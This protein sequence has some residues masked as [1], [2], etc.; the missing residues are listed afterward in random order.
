MLRTYSIYKKLEYH[1]DDKIE[2]LQNET[3]WNVLKAIIP[4][5]AVLF[6]KV[7]PND[8]STIIVIS[9]VFFIISFKSIRTKIYKIGVFL[10]IIDFITNFRGINTDKNESEIVQE[11]DN[12]NEEHNNNIKE[13]YFLYSLYPSKKDFKQ[14]Y[15]ITIENEL[16]NY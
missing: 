16:F 13:L 12:F 10:K 15:V 2:E 4:F 1:I 3:F 8:I 6:S 9:L 14:F 11:I 7:F 5:G